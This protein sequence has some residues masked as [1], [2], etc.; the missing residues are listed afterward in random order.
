MPGNG[1]ER[2]LPVEPREWEAFVDALQ[3]LVLVAGTAAERLNSRDQVDA[4]REVLAATTR[5]L[6]LA[7]RMLPRRARPARGNT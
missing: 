3:V 2:R 4:C 6:D 7:E 5:V 1:T